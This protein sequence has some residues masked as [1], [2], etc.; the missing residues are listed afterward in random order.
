MLILIFFA[1]I[2]WTIRFLVHRPYL[3]IVFEPLIV[4]VVIVFV[5]VVGVVVVVVAAVAVDIIIAAARSVQRPSTLHVMEYQ[6]N[7][8]GGCR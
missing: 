4:V 2:F 5:V 7:G 6:R 8:S 3:A 1:D